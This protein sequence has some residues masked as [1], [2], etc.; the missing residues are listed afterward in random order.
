MLHVQINKS[1]INN[2]KR[3]KYKHAQRTQREQD[4]LILIVWIW[5]LIVYISVERI[6]K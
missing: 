3:Q 4:R 5:S 1:E 2:I 6:Y